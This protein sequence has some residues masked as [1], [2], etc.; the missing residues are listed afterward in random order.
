MLNAIR[1]TSAALGF[2]ALAA[3]CGGVSQE[4][5]NAAVSEADKYKQDAATQSQRVTDCEAK[6]SGMSKQVTGLEQTNATLEQKNDDYKN[7]SAAL[8]ADSAAGM[9]EIANLSGLVTIRL[10]E[11]VLFAPGSAAIIKS[12]K[13]E[14]KKV[15]AAMKGVTGRVF[16]VAGNTDNRPIK[17]RQFPS[18]WELSTARA[19][20][21]VKFFIA[22]G[23]DPKTLGVAAYGP[24]HP[25]APNDTAEGRA[26]NRRIDIAMAPP[27]SDLPTAK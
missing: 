7:M 4:K 26:K 2:A 6:V 12:G 20:A 18:N 27:P 5:Y 11:K 23:V 19:L 1:N 14:L 22:E 10:P 17:T 8:A 16:Y 21:V 24:Y 15:A 3:G 9:V 13:A 25:I